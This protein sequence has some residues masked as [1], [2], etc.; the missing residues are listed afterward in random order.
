VL[1]I[2]DLSNIPLE[3]SQ[4]EET[5]P[6][7]IAGG[8]ATF[9]PEPL[10]F[11]ID[12][13]VLGDGEEVIK[14]LVRCVK[15]AKEGKWEK[16][17]LLEELVK[18]EGVYV[19]FFYEAEY[20]ASGK[21]KSLKPLKKNIPSSIKARKVDLN[22]A[23]HPISPLVPLMEVVHNRVTV[24]LLRG[25]S[26]RC[27]FC[28]ATFVSRPLRQRKME[29]V[30]SYFKNS[31]KNTGYDELSVCALNSSNYS[32]LPALLKA[33]IQYCHQHHLSLSFSSL[34][35]DTTLIEFLEQLTELRRR[36]ITLAIEA[37]SERLRN[38]INKPF[39]KSE[40]LNT[41][42]A[43]VE[44][45]WWN[46]KLYFMI[47]LPGERKED[48][49]ALPQLVEEILSEN[50]KLK[51][52]VVNISPFVPRPHTP[53]QWWEMEEI[54]S[55]KEKLAF[56]KRKLHHPRIKVSYRAPEMA[57]IEALL[58][59][60]DRRV[61]LLLLEAWKRGA[62]FDEWTEQFN[63]KLWQRSITACSLELP[64]N[65][66]LSQVL[67][68]EHIDIGVSKE[69]LKKEFLKAKLGMA[70]PPRKTLKQKS[71]L[72][73]L[74]KQFLKPLLVW[75]RKQRFRIR[76]KFKK[77]GLLRFIS[78]LE[79]LSLFKKALR[80]T[81]L[82][83]VYT[84]GYHQE[85]KLQAGPPLPVGIASQEEYLDFFLFSEYNLEEIKSQ[86]NENLPQ[87]T[88][89]LEVFSIPRDAKSLT[90]IIWKVTY[91]VDYPAER[92]LKE[93][94][95]KAILSA[96]GEIEKENLTSVTFT[97]REGSAKKS[98]VKTLFNLLIQEEKTE[99]KIE[100]LKMRC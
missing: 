3:A 37:A 56:L 23:P 22:K 96:G 45:G 77:V 99:C 16:R 73:H 67:P 76:V 29:Q 49:E 42:R 88:H 83:V 39:Q 44:K 13:F 65:Y 5:F 75:Q 79:L 19:P 4:R 35:V 60:G 70:T 78:H 28:E 52:L 2:L 74:D 68:W 85:P 21:F 8:I 59:R 53:F 81:R 64:L 12:C 7:I 93:K 33:L 36:N 54:F 86:L 66:T 26:E 38:I 41:I 40:L 69:Y 51:R 18:L 25:C 48:I 15:Q 46:L 98:F 20:T 27:R 55:L 94:I 97:L 87:E 63:F 62:R 80:R 58:A 14:E 90:K 71:H 72:L 24:E 43:F 95:K 82:P 30:V 10:A 17:K 57:F 1:T 50:K 89:I 92:Y 32:E 100:K 61:S 91:R 9:N 84:Q 31:V 11:F 47:G 34:R 6:L